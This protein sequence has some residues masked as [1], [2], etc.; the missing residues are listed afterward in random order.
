MDVMGGWDLLNIAV[1]SPNVLP[2]PVTSFR[3]TSVWDR[4]AGRRARWDGEGTVA[5]K[6]VERALVVGSGTPSIENVASSC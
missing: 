2:A 3:I 5:L 4:M 1:T 6:T